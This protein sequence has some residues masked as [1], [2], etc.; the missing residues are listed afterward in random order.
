MGK[1]IKKGSVEMKLI[2][3]TKRIIAVFTAVILVLP[4]FFME[5]DVKS[6]T[7]KL[8]KPKAVK[9]SVAANNT[10]KISWNPVKG[11]NKYEVYCAAGKNEKYKKIKTVS[12]CSYKKSNYAAGKNYSY[13]VRAYRIQSGKKTYGSFSA[14]KSITLPK[15]QETSTS[16]PSKV[17]DLTQSQ[18]PLTPTPVPEYA[19]IED[20]NKTPVDLPHFMFFTVTKVSEQNVY[21]SSET[22]PSSKPY[23]VEKPDNFNIQEGMRL[24]VV[25]PE[26][27]LATENSENQKIVQYTTIDILGEGFWFQNPLYVKQISGGILY[28]GDEFSEMV[29]TTLDL[30]FNEILVTK[31]GQF[32]TIND[33]KTGDKLN[34]YVSTFPTAS[35]PGK[36][37]DCT[38]ISI[39]D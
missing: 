23:I 30:R 22:N 28:L 35:I 38:K 9:I 25:N 15:I 10:I 4:F 31:N 2:A 18:V 7:I 17:P 36:I 8:E 39:L 19:S 26:I 27:D 32:A 13:K 14:V 11:A 12:K 1:Q 34:F 24:K 3:K 33:I 29:T 37:I 6:A 21:L 16:V 20:I 5:V